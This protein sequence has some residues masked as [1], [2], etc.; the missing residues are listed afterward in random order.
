[1][2]F[3]HLFLKIYKHRKTE[4]N[5]FTVIEPYCDGGDLSHY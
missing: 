4:T 5:N 3:D 1:M 2:N